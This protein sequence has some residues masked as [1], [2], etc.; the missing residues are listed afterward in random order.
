MT[1]LWRRYSVSIILVALFLTSWGLQ[2]WTGWIEFKARQQT[3]GEPGNVLGPNGYLWHWGHTTFQNWQ[4]EFLHLIVFLALVPVIVQQTR[5][6]SRADDD[7]LRRVH[8]AIRRIEE[9]LRELRSQNP[10]AR[11]PRNHATTRPPGPDE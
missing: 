11:I 1:Q 2:T 10:E 5:C 7:E 3:H 8:Q 4:S 6:S 9:Q